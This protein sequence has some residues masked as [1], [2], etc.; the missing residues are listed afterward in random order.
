[1]IAI[2]ANAI[3]ASLLEFIQEFWCIDHLNAL[4]LAGRPLKAKADEVSAEIRRAAITIHPLYRVLLYV[5]SDIA[6]HCAAIDAVG[7]KRAALLHVRHIEELYTVSKFLLATPE[8]YEEFAWR[9]ENFHT[10]HAIRNRILNLKQPL[11]PQMTTWLEANIE[12]MRKL[13]STKFDADPTKCTAQ[14]EKLSNW[15]HKIP[16][17][18]I[19]KKA[20]RL[21]SYTSMAYDWNSQAVH[22]SPLG[23]MYMGYQLDHQDYGDV[24]LGSACT[25]LHKMCHECSSIV[26]DQE[27]LRKYHLRQVLLETYEM[28]CNRPAQY[29][30]LANKLDR[31]KAL[32]QLLLQKPFDF[33]AVMNA[34][35]SP[36]PK[37]PLIL[38]LPQ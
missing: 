5:L 30:D 33:N 6:D 8:R 15:L 16:L 18:E 12:T 35:I 7:K 29:V 22:L 32:T 11:D 10:L 36:P 19:F 26:T 24:A 27:S 13:F 38:D 2:P 9:W 4:G 37:D 31:Y 25:H 34:S 20:G 23:N 3:Q 1:M 14:W 17:N 21:G 28:L